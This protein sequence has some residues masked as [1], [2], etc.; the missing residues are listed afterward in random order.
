[1][2]DLAIA[3]Y[4]CR[5]L[6]KNN[7][8]L[9]LR[10]DLKDLFDSYDILCF[11]ESWYSTQDLGHLNSLHE[12]FH[13]VGVSTTNLDE[14]IIHGHPPGGVAIM[15]HNR[16]ET[17]VKILDL[18]L[19]WC[20]GIEISIDDRRF[21]IF[22][23]YMPYQCLLHEEIYLEK[24]GLLKAILDEFDTT[25]YAVFG[26]WNA[27]LKDVSNSMFANH[28]INFSSDNNLAISTK[29]LL[30]SDSYTYVSDSWSTVSWLDHVLCSRDMH[31]AIIDTNI[32]YELTVSDHIPFYVTF[33]MGNVPQITSHSN[34]IN[35]K[36][37]W[38]ALSIKDID[39]YCN[40]TEEFLK[41][42]NIPVA[43]ITC[44]DSNCIDENHRSLLN[45]FYNDI[46]SQLNNASKQVFTFTNNKRAN[47]VPGWSEYVSDHYTVVKEAHIMWKDAGKPRQGPIHDV[48]IKSRAQFKYALRYVKN[49]ESDMRKDSLARKLANHSPAEFWKEIKAMNNNK[50]PLPSCIEGVSGAENIADLWRG[51]FED[52]LNSVGHSKQAK[53]D[54]VVNEEKEDINVVR[55]E[56]SSAIRELDINKSCGGDSIYAEHLKYSS[57]RIVPMLSMLF[58]GLFVHGILPDNMLSVIISPVIKDKAGSI[59]SKDNYRPIA[60]ASVISKVLEKIILNR[61][62]EYITTSSNQFGFKKKLGTDQCVYTLKEV[63]HFYK[64]SGSS[65]FISFL[66]ASKAFDRVNHSVLFKKLHERNIPKYII[67]ILVFWYANQTFCIRWG[68][69]Y[70][71]EFYVSNGVRQGGILSPF[72]FN[73][74]TDDLSSSLNKCNAGCY[75]MQNII[76]HLLYADDLVL[77]APSVRGLNMLLRICETFGITHDVKFN[78]KKSVVM[79][80]RSEY[81]MNSV[82]PNFKLNGEI[83]KEVKYYKY[84]GCIISNDLKDDL[85]IDRQRRKL[86][87]QGNIILRKF[88]MCSV[89]VKLKLFTAY[90]STMYVPHLWINYNRCTINKLYIAYHSIFK[91]FV[92]FSKFES[93]SL[94]CTVFDVQCCQSV[95][96]N[97][98]HKFIQRLDDSSNDLIIQILSSSL[99]YT[100]YMRKHWR[101]LLYIDS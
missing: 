85:D 36:L 14:R 79:I 5:G 81:L 78:S 41:T 57:D 73:V 1:M 9:F 60:L 38:D 43:A 67:R 37:N 34:G 31:N 72:L 44:V 15:W 70:S 49:N 62:D 58:T 18:K 84:L 69:V 19:D 6:P 99:V 10:P 63:L 39:R 35:P 51:H 47:I 24:L 28:L 40:L 95:I 80:V 88:F 65:V 30:N 54:G 42:I 46:I 92:N 56:V 100:S 55:N 68:N 52:L 90:C 32:L 53:F 82:L 16:L 27:N 66:D 77:F 3:S 75:I 74:Y 26:D 29:V 59:S 12:N 87:V 64:T 50:T 21:I 33:D 89:E 17:N 11:Q 94:L 97:L 86:Y 45:R 61:I 93:T 83:L 2:S 98:I 13:G 91:Q 96:R 7:R 23:V 4:N 76:N 8:T 22:S 71:G 25:C 48:Y 20:V 101:S